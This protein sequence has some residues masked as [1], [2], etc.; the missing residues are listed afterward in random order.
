MNIK[1]YMQ[2]IKDLYKRNGKEYADHA[3]ALEKLREESKGIDR[4]INLSPTGKSAKHAQIT[5]AI[6]SHKN[7]MESIAVK[8]KAEAQTMRQNAKREFYADPASLDMNLITIVKSGIC[9]LDEIAT[10]ANRSNET[11]RR[12]LGAYLCK[13]EDQ[14]KRALGIQLGAFAGDKEMNLIDSLIGTGNYLIG[15]APFTGE[16]G[17][18][19]WYEKFDS[20]T[21][22]LFNA[23]E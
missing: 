22:D 12:V 6:V 19:S 11:T 15:D 9:G 20:M 7:A 17:A 13:S 16:E 23:A 1:Q 21:A 3:A 2:E 4:D 10:L 18:S 5:D 8:T 14:N